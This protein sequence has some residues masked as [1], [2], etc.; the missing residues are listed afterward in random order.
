MVMP[1]MVPMLKNPAQVIALVTRPWR[2]AI[3]MNGSR[4][5]TSRAA[6]SVHSTAEPANRATICQESQR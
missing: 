5:V 4:A 2:I 1:M 3:G 6:N